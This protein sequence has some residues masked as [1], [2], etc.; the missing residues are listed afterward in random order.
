MSE[1][2]S[3]IDVNSYGLQSMVA[4][5]GGGTINLQDKTVTPTITQQ[6]VTA[7]NGYDGLHEV[8]VEAMENLTPLIAAQEQ[9]IAQ[10]QEEVNNKAAGEPNLQ[11][12]EITITQNGTTTVEPDTGYDGLSDVDVTV[13]VPKPVLPN[14]IRFGSSASTSTNMDFLLDVD[15]SNVTTMASMFE[16]YPNLTT[17]PLFDTSNVTNM[18]AMFTRCSN[19]TTVPLFNTSNVTNMQDMLSNCGNLTTVPLFDTS[20]VTNMSYMIRNCPNLTT[21]PEFDT[22]KVEDMRNMFSSC[23]SLSNESL[24]NILAMCTKAVAY[25]QT[26]TLAYIGL[27]SAQA[28]TCQSLSNWNDFVAAGWSSGY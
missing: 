26:K 17:V 3:L 8:T 18:R 7:D 22:S 19:L 11:S 21:V 14:G 13:N 25:T 2:L 16:N 23:N 4:G 15:I 28:T 9:I 24:N 27:S 10:L 5:S 6:I 12:K 20:N 1:V